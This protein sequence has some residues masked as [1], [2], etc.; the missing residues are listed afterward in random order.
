[1]NE[2]QRAERI[3]GSLANVNEDLLALLDDVGQGINVR[4]AAAWE[5]SKAFIDA[6]HA[7]LGRFQTA[8]QEISEAIRTK[9]G[10]ADHDMPGNRAGVTTKPNDPM[11]T[12]RR[13]HYLGEDFTFTRPVGFTLG[14]QAFTGVTTWRELHITLCRYLAE[15]NPRRFA[16]LPE[17]PKFI[18][19][20]GYPM[21]R[22]TP[23]S[24]LRKWAFIMPDVYM[25]VHLSADD[26][27][28]WISRL[29]ADFSV[30]EA[31]MKIYLKREREA[32]G[33]DVA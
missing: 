25:Y 11:F 8:S 26:T 1:M 23:T 19:Q 14:E 27:C 4:D 17:N 7:A 21:Y 3:L 33:D 6:Y 32:A 16:A 15:Q 31:S 12:S 29:L 9:V 13:A 2:R 10:I 24:E 28:K 5:A 18:S 30:P 20:Q 22:H